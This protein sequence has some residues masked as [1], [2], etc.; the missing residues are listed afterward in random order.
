MSAQAILNDY[1]DLQED[2]I[3]AACAFAARFSQ[4]KRLDLLA[5]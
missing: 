5:A 3:R 4:L 2:D 1:P